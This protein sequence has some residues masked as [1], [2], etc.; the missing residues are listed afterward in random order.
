MPNP[1]RPSAHITHE[2]TRS[3]KSLFTAREHYSDMLLAFIFGAACGALAAVVALAV[4]T[5]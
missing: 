1:K 5:T 2:R 3:S 4:V